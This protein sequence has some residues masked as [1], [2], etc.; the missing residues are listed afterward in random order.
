[1]APRAGLASRHDVDQR[2]SGTQLRQRD[3]LP[4]FFLRAAEDVDMKALQHRRNG[5]T[6]HHMINA[7]GY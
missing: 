7:R 1:L 6:Q 3:R 5:R 4:A 2:A